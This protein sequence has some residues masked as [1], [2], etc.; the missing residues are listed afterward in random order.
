V[1][2]FSSNRSKSPHDSFAA[3]IKKV[4]HTLQSWRDWAPTRCQSKSDDRSIVGLN[5]RLRH[6]MQPPPRL[7]VSALKD[8]EA[9]SKATVFELGFMCAS[10]VSVTLNRATKR[11]YTPELQARIDSIIQLN[12][13]KV[14]NLT[15]VGIQ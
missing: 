13:I 14:R 10:S 7:F 15:L 4:S 8:D 12:M 11:K 2:F 9:K 6:D 1:H 5:G 3:Y